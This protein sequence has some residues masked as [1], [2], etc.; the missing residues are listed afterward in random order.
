MF[1]CHVCREEQR[2]GVEDDFDNG[3]IVLR[4]EAH[5]VIGGVYSQVWKS[6]F[7]VCGIGVS[8]VVQCADA[9]AGNSTGIASKLTMESW[10]M[11]EMG[12]NCDTLSYIYIYSRAQF[13]NRAQARYILRLPRACQIHT[14]VSS[15]ASDPAR[16]QPHTHK[17][18]WHTPSIPLYVAP[19]T[20]NPTR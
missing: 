16:L 1:P 13:S 5:F 14:A 20:A 2:W 4:C 12:H 7:V 15:Y 3:E 17:T 10:P 6:G 9:N 18:A 11:I 19:P 8:S